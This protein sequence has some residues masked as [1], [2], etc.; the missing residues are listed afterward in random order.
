MRIS[1]FLPWIL[2][3]V[4]IASCGGGSQVDAGGTGGGNQGTGGFGPGGTCEATD[5]CPEGFVCH[6][7]EQV[8]VAG[9][10]CSSHADCGARAHCDPSAGRCTPSGT[11][12]PCGDDAN[13][14]EGETC[15]AGYCGCEGEN[16]NADNVPPNVLIVLDRS[17]SMVSNTVPGTGGQTRWA[18]ARE[19]VSSLVETYGDGIRFGLALFPGTAQTC[20]QG[21]QN[22][23]PGNVFIDP[24]EGTAAEIQDFI[25][26]DDTTTC[27]YGTPIRAM[28]ESLADY[29]GLEDPDRANYIVFVADGISQCSGGNQP[30][31]PGPAVSALFDK[32]PSVRTFAIG[33]SGDVGS[34][35]LDDIAER[36]GTARTDGPPFYY[37]ADDADQ[38]EAAFAS[39]AG[40]VLSCTYTLSERPEDLDQFYVYFDEDGVPRDTSGADGWD[41][42]TVSNQVNFSGAACDALRGGEVGDLVLVY[43]CPPRVDVR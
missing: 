24:A 15:L 22:C 43:G 35:E 13:C 41:Y 1:R 14:R 32:S 40:S 4:W 33:F 18:V 16:F 9:G 12:S 31:D 17:G 10:P 25:N 23:G 26:S 36:G 30:G 39:I 2:A 29:E 42:D 21:G 19:A 11:G 5:A 34:E 6:P 8:C 37:Q 3:S 27:S 20:S 7:T 28:M 38:L